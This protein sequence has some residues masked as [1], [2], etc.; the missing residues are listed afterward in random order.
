MAYDVII[1][2]PQGT[3][4]DMRNLSSV[5]AREEISSVYDSTQD[6]K[7]IVH[8]AIAKERQISFDD[9]GYYVSITTVE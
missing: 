7:L 9:D 2:S 4:C 1:R 8:I 5:R 6:K 3:Y